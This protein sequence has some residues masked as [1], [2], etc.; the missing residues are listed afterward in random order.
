MAAF[1]G[2]ELPRRIAGALAYKGGLAE[3]RPTAPRA[4]VLDREFSASRRHCPD[5][6]ERATTRLGRERIEGEQQLCC[7]VIRGVEV[8]D[9]D[10]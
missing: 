10:I 8:G 2:G 3:Y 6:L 4:A 1:D 7:V 5:Q 9:R